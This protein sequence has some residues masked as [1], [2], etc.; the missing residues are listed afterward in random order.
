[1]KS[2]IEIGIL[3]KKLN[4]A[5][6]QYELGTPIMSDKEWDDLYFELKDWEEKTGIVFS[7]SPTQKI[8]YEVVTEL[9]KV[10]HNHPMLSLD[11]TKNIKDIEKF[12]HGQDW[13]AMAKM[14]GLTC[15]LRYFN[16]ELVGAETRGNGQI[17]EDIL[18]NAKVIP[19]IP[20]TIHWDD[21][22]IIDGEIICTYDNFE[23]FKEDYRNPRNFA[24]GSIRL[25]DSKECAKRKLTFVAW[26]V[27]SDTSEFLSNKL[28]YL[29]EE[30]FLIVPY[31]VNMP[32]DTTTLEEY[33]DWIKKRCDK[34]S[35]PIDGVVFKYPRDARRFL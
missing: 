20:N 21:E 34:L 23:S 2:K 27:I 10:K 5:T 30:G 32:L 9:K 17:G 14:D 25:L 28:S 24:S 16:G 3:I 31:C 18:H 22:L 12:I 19:S 15:S 13:I 35:Y 4:E 7:N 26:D 1:M 11:K 6:K 33:I 29:E 8:H